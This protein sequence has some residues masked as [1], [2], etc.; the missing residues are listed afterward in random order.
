MFSSFLL[1]ESIS[2]CIKLEDKN[3]ERKTNCHFIITLSSH[4]NF[5][6]IIYRPCSVLVLYAVRN[7]LIGIRSYIS[8]RS[9]DSGMWMTSSGLES[10]EVERGK[11]GLCSIKWSV[12][13]SQ[14]AESASN[15]WRRKDRTV[16][17]NVMWR[18][19]H[20][21]RLTLAWPFTF[22]VPSILELKHHNDGT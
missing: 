1:K 16:R 9:H 12:G 15:E 4:H 8:N 17:N 19:L 21:R 2:K 13:K 7:V 3:G 5:I 18:T 14:I 22:I 11:R 20:S 10:L 6:F